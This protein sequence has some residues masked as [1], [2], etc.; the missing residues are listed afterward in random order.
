[1][2]FTAPFWSRIAIVIIFCM[3]WLYIRSF[4]GS[5]ITSP[6][7]RILVCFIDIVCPFVY[8]VAFAFA[9]DADHPLTTLGCFVFIALAYLIIQSI[10]SD[11][12][13]TVQGVA[14]T[15]LAIFVAAGGIIGRLL[16]GATYSWI[17]PCTLLV[18]VALYGIF[19][20]Q[21]WAVI[22]VGMGER[23][24]EPPSAAAEKVAGI[25]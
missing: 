23:R 15:S 17:D 5:H 21:Q 24:A 8:Q 1:L 20:Y 9:G 16:W 3:T 14:C 19:L 18:L 25:D 11:K 4:K 2:L 12:G 10:R 22:Q 6:S 13:G 7:A